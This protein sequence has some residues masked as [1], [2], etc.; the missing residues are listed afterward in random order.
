M[1]LS[2]LAKIAL[3]LAVIGLVDA[4]Y[5]TVTHY[6]N[7][8][9]ACSDTG[10]INCDAVLNSQYS[11]LLGL[12]FTVWGLIFF[13]IEI[14]LILVIKNKDLFVIYNGI[15]IAFVAYLLFVEYLVGNICI[16]CTLVHILVVLI[17]VI[18]I[19]DYNAKPKHA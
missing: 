1:A 9:V 19:L 11:V 16:Y 17:F 3:I 14:G 18:S 10:I 6:T 7:T 2:K 4:L 8:P 15:G 12:P 5:L 13:I